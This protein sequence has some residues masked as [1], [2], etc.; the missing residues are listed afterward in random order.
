MPESDHEL[1]ERCR[2]GDA[3]AFEDLL[4]RWEAPVARLLARLTDSQLSRDPSEVDDLSQE[5]FL[6]VLGALDRYESNGS[7]ST[8]LYRIALNVAHDSHRRRRSRL[9]LQ[10]ANRPKP[11]SPGPAEVASRQEL[12]AHVAGALSTLPRKLR[13][14][15]ILKHYGHLTFAETSQ[16][17][18]V[19]VG[20]VKSR[21][22]SALLKLRAELKRRGIDEREL[23]T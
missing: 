1:I 2:R 22:Q 5:V 16:V 13:E 9:R 8:W 15:L 20:T 10:N 11:K 3:S 21:V 14:P 4:R 18:G 7:F 23:E 6:R 17:I 12:A 19:P